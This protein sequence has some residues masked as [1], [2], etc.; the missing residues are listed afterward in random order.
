VTE[1]ALRKQRMDLKEQCGA[2]VSRC[3]RLQDAVH[4]FM[5][6]WRLLAPSRLVGD[7]ARLRCCDFVERALHSAI[8]YGRRAFGLAAR[9]GDV[10]GQAKVKDDVVA[11]LDLNQRRYENARQVFEA[12]FLGD[13]LPGEFY[14]ARTLYCR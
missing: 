8:E 13:E 2:L 4:E 10:L 14:E 5:N 12:N 7:P 1:L 11:W 3:A 6:Q 9:A